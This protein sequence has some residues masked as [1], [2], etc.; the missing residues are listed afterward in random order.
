LGEQTGFVLRGNEY[1]SE[2]L[3]ESDCG[4]DG[5]VSESRVSDVGFNSAKKEFLDDFFVVGSTGEVESCAASE[6]GLVVLVDESL[7]L[8]HQVFDCIHHHSVETQELK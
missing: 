2:V 5:S 8:E 3:T 1:V 7:F 4:V 6:G